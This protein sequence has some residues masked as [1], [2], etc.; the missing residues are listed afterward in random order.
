MVLVLAS[1]L[2]AQGCCAGRLGRIT[3]REGRGVYLR[4]DV[5]TRPDCGSLDFHVRASQ[6]VLRFH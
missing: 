3:E 2:R 6:R 4:M 1:G 5:A